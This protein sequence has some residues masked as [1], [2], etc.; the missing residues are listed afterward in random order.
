M[1]PSSYSTYFNYWFILALLIIIIL[2]S[3]VGFIIEPKTFITNLLS[4]L[5]VLGTSIVVALL[6]VDKYIKYQK[7]KQ[8]SI[9]RDYTLKTIAVHLC[10]IATCIFTHYPSIDPEM[11]IPIF[12]GHS[13]LPNQRTLQSF[14]WLLNKLYDY[15]LP[16]NIAIN[17][18]T[19]DIAIDYYKSV[20]WDLDQIQNILIPRV[21]QSS[22]DTSLINLLIEFDDA[23]R[24][25]HHS[26]IAHEQVVTHSVFKNVISLIRCAERVY[27]AICEYYEIERHP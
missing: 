20:E 9:V 5:S 17:K 11:M 16:Q 2:T 25:L 18:S 6:V 13:L 4:G 3:I 23:R 10:E 8:W 27:R 12:E 22:E 21:I 1:K 15:K 24:E 7:A 19:S 26:I 14:N